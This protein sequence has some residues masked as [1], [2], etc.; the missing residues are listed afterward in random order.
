M[1]TALNINKPENFDSFYEEYITPHITDYNKRDKAGRKTGT[2]GIVMI[3][4]TIASF[5]VFYKPTKYPIAVCLLPF[6]LLAIAIVVCYVYFQKEKAITSYFKEKVVHAILNHVLP[7][8]S[9]QY[10]SFMSSKLYNAAALHRDFNNVYDGNDLIKGQYKQVSFKASELAVE[11]VYKSIH[12]I[13]FKGI[14]MSANIPGIQGGTYIWPKDDVQLGDDFRNQRILSLPPLSRVQTG[15]AVF[16]KYFSVYSSYPAEAATLLTQERMQGMINLKYHLKKNIRYS[17][18]AGRFYTCIAS[19]DDLL[20]P[21]KDLRDRES[22]KA[23]FF[24][25]LVYPAIINQL[26]LYEY[27]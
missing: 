14:F 16:D 27:I 24:T 20:E 11:Y 25:I 5:V 17:F 8:A 2:V 7:G 4:V 12:Q 10:D 26:K 18:V 13:I 15:S 21:L 3:F 9:I 1:E 22:V 19:E 23:Y 6:F